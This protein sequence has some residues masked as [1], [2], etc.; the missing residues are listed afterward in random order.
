MQAQKKKNLVVPQFPPGGGVK[1]HAP[2]RDL[3]E[4]TNLMKLFKSR[5]G[6]TLS[7]T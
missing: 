4:F 6:A 2:A 7:P 1:K 5:N 3:V